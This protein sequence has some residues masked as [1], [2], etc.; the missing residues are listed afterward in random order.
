MARIRSYGAALLVFGLVSGM[1]CTSSNKSSVQS[2]ASSRVKGGGLWLGEA[3]RRAQQVRDVAYDLDVELVPAAPQMQGQVKLSFNLLHRDT[4]LTIDFRGGE[5]LGV[6]WNGKPFTNF[7]YNSEFLT[8]PREALVVGP[9]VAEI[10]Y[11]VPYSRMG[12]GIYRFKDP[13]DQRV[14]VYTDFEPYDASLFMPCFDQPDLKAT[15]LLSVMAP[16]DWTV[17]ANTKESQVERAGAE[18]KKWFFPRTA[19]FSTYILALIA[20]PFKIWESKAGDIPLRLLARQ[21]M[22]K[23]VDP[24]EWFSTTKQGFKFF[25]GYFDYKYPFKKYDQAIVPDFNAGAMENVAAVTFSERF[26]RRGKPT[27]SQRMDLAGVIL[28]E[29]AHMWFGNLVTMKWWN[30]LWLN[31]SFAT[32]MATKAL[33][34]ATPFKDA[35]TPFAVEEKEWAYWED[36]LVTT[37]AIVTPVENTDRAFANFDGITYAK[38]ASSLKQLNFLLGENVFRDGVRRY[39]KK[40]AYG[41]TELGDFMGALAEASGRNLN[42]W[43]KEWLET[44]GLSRIRSEVVCQS[45]RIE[46]LSIVQTPPIEF[47]QARDQRLKVSLWYLDSKGALRP[48]VVRAVEVRE[49]MDMADLK[50]QACPELVFANAEDHAY[51]RLVLDEKSLAAVMKHGAGI[52]DDEVKGVLVA[53]IWNQVVEGELPVQSFLALAQ[54]MLP[55]IKNLDIARGVSERVV[56]RGAAEFR[57][58]SYLP[59]TTPSEARERTAQV[60]SWVQLYARLLDRAEPGSDWQKLWMDGFAHLAESRAALSRLE[61]W[62]SGRETRVQKSMDQ[63]R[64]WFVLT[65]IRRFGGDPEG[66]LIAAEK[67]RDS[68]SRGYEASLAAE[69]IFPNPLAKRGWLERMTAPQQMTLAQIR[70]V[71]RNLL[72]EEQDQSRSALEKPILDVLGKL[73]STDEAELASTLARFATPSRC[74]G[75][76]ADTLGQFIEKH[77]RPEFSR[78][79]LKSLKV[80]RQEAQRCVR[81]RDVARTAHSKSV[82]F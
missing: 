30:D 16:A 1:G 12:S 5:V 31:E 38:G 81:A 46:R 61:S 28:H 65:A 52:A 73:K 27:R 32:F 23:Y 80:Q 57:A 63:D 62:L 8:I 15:Y 7:K 24:E 75:A 40:H 43:T 79:A 51:G 71:A 54:R 21:S 26:V 76:S 11:S 41:N 59:R 66:A 77:D 10:T 3:M 34:A 17:V 6:K 18:F 14:Y 22:A 55:S 60:E 42:Q 72:P 70:S 56:G 64:R 68:S 50:G 2:S 20:G 13:E 53:S 9:Q 47:P 49:K 48:K 69:A 29:M 37:H 33:V 74:D 19:K 45:G 35:W 44:P 25:N 82:L 58:I 36:Q 39:F 4:D 78:A 67:A